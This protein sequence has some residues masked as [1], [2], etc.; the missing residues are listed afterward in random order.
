MGNYTG[1]GRWSSL[2]LPQP[3]HR[4]SRHHDEVG[5][6]LPG[7]SGALFLIIARLGKIHGVVKPQREFHRLRL[8]GQMPRLVK[9]RQALGEMLLGMIMTLRFGMGPGEAIIGP[10][11]VIE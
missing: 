10:T 5:E 6:A 3:A 11:S 2:F 9:F 7:E 8:P 4:L 1:E